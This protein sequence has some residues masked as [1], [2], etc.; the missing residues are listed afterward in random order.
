MITTGKA[1]DE[2]EAFKV[3]PAALHKR[4]K[5]CKNKPPPLVCN[6]LQPNTLE[7]CY[8]GGVAVMGFGA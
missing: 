4:R 2:K 7:N 1:Y 6:S 3:T 8:S 5:A